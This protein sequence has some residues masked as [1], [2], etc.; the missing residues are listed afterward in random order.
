MTTNQSM[1]S[2]RVKNS[3]D[4]VYVVGDEVYCKKHKIKLTFSDGYAA[5]D[6]ITISA[7]EDIFYMARNYPNMLHISESVK[8]TSICNIPTKLLYCKSCQRQAMAWW[9]SQ[10]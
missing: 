1:I 2:D 5:E 8:A 9:N 3:R 6:N 7:G 10:K 4:D